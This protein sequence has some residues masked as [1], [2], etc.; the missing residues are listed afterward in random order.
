MTSA[1]TF[2]KAL[3]TVP[4]YYIQHLEYTLKTFIKDYNINRY[5]IDCV[6]LVKQIRDSKSI[7]LQIGTVKD[8]SD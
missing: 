7:P 2:I 3:H 6:A 5:P 8:V 1:D 4:L